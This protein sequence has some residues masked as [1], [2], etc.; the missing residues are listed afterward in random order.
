MDILEAKELVI[1]A[2]HKLVESKLIA[3]TWG[4][5]SCRVSDTQFVITPSGKPYENL[6]PEE[7]VLV[8]IDTLE[9]EGDIKPSSEKGIHAAAY[10]LRPGVNFV[11][12]THQVN[13]SV[14]SVLG[15]EMPVNDSEFSKVIGTHVPLA[16]YGMPSTGKLKKAVA[17]AI[18]GCRSGAVIMA[19]HGAL[20][21]GEDYDEAF[22]IASVLETACG[23]YIAQYAA[24]KGI[25]TLRAGAASQILSVNDEPAPVCISSELKGDVI[26]LTD[27]VNFCKANAETGEIT[28]GEGF[29]DAL[30]LH[31]SIY[32]ARDDIKVILHSATP[33]ILAVSKLDKTINPMLDDYA[34]IAG[35]GVRCIHP[36]VDGAAEGLKGRNAVF[37]LGEGAL[38][39]G[40][41][42]SDAHATQMVL[43][44]N[45]RCY[46]AA[47]LF[48]DFRFISPLET[49]LMRLIYVKKYSK[50]AE[51]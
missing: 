13:A 32:R 21:M 39:C 48:G 34:Q 17:S 31:R 43:D 46:I 22:R 4:N 14:V 18:A 37:L 50:K 47:R 3:R 24:K 36:Q 49:R 5:V 11:I 51:E 15:R 6:T 28:S 25:D 42:V 12:H 38:C 35:A 44:K 2:G 1:R 23:E 30:N 29:G 41:N 20:C 27:G 9:Y 8:N 19:H 16:A 40:Q 10:K 45:C 33:D 26:L 7:I